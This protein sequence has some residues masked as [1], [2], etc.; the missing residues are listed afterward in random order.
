MFRGSF[1]IVTAVDEQPESKAVDFSL[2]D[3]KFMRAFQGSWSVKEGP[4]GG[5]KVE[6]TL[7]VTPLLSPPP[8]FANYTSKIFVK[9]VTG[10][11][12]DLQQAMAK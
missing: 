11:M 3:S 12:E 8:A 10:I 4:E 9:Q 5:C 7:Q 6:H 1:S 2:V